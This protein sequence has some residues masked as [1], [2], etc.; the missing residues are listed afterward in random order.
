M[1]GEAHLHQKAVVSLSVGR[2]STY[3]LK[4]QS[5]EV[6]IL[7]INDAD[8]SGTQTIPASCQTYIRQI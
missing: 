7:D 4:Y 8:Y 5:K 3:L 1:S 2:L 6:A